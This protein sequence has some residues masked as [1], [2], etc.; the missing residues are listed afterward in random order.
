MASK[1]QSSQVCLVDQLQLVEI[2]AQTSQ[3]IF[4]I[5]GVG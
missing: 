3:K 2:E 4:S 1:E 5:F